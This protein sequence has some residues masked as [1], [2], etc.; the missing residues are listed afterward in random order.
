M[1]KSITKHL[2]KKNTKVRNLKIQKKKADTKFFSITTKFKKGI[3][4]L[5]LNKLK[6]FNLVIRKTANRNQDFSIFF[7]N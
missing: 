6:G 1:M 2:F 4:T 3:Q 5:K 7:D